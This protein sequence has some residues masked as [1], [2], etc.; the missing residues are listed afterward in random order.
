MRPNA[1]SMLGR[2]SYTTHLLVYPFLLGAYLFG[3]K[4]YMAYSQKN[5]E[6]L[7]WKG[8]PKAQKVDP[9]LFN[10][11]TPIPYHNNPEL[12]YAFAHINM[13][14]YLNENQINTEEYAWKN[15]EYSF[16][17]DHKFGYTYNWT[18]LHSPIDDNK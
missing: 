5:Q 13:H 1:L 14:T 4:P 16:D 18:S 9:D 2:M 17:H 8:M 7:E 11:F 15:F 3:V 10:P 12:K 6:E